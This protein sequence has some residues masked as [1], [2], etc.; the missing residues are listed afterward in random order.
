MRVS[1][2]VKGGQWNYLG[3]YSFDAGDYTVVL[4]DDVNGYVVV[5]AIKFEPGSYTP[6]SS[7]PI[8]DKLDADVIDVIKH[9]DRRWNILRCGLLL[10]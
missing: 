7:W 6:G 10:Y 3:T 8:A 9:M 2:L 4:A 5:D 1:Q